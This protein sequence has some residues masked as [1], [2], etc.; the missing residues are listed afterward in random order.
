MS[1]GW[2]A[3]GRIG[4]FSL[5]VDFQQGTI[6]RIQEPPHTMK[7]LKALA[8]AAMMAWG[9]A[10]A[11]TPDLPSPPPPPLPAPRLTDIQGAVLLD[12]NSGQ[13][14]MADHAEKSLNPSGLVKLMT[15]YVLYQAEKQGMVQPQAAVRVSDEAWHAQGSRMFIQPGM[16]VTLTQLESGLLIDG[17]NDAAIAIA[18]AVAGSV[19]GFVGLMNRDAL[20]MGLRHTR[21]TNPDG[22][23][24]PGQ[25]ST[26]LDIAH[27]SERL[28]QAYPQVLRVAGKTSYA[29][30]RITQFNYNPLA[31]QADIDG[32]GVGLAAKDSW[33][34]DASASRDGR[35][36]VAV[37]LG[38]PSRRAAGGDASALLRYGWNGWRDRSL[39]AAGQVVA[40]VHHKGWS[41]EDLQVMTARA[42]TLSEPKQEG[43]HLQTQFIPLTNLKAPIRA[44]E[45][46]G[47]LTVRWSGHLLQRVPVVAKSAVQPAGWL[48]RLLHAGESWL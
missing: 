19:G 48:T 40:N 45:P 15:A 10:N 3:R 43:T 31:G 11:A 30:N 42:V 36:L 1:G 13:V 25:T 27:L 39:Y 18:Q 32:L 7:S 17:G 46:V 37:V 24:Q 12:V 29:Y 14:L 6:S 34:L 38:A 20:A 5:W 41:P 28:I 47:M 35:T 21:F 22:L 8:L 9:G 44:G 4:N 33:N 16:P 2:S 23:P 26:A